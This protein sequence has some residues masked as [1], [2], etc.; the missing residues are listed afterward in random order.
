MQA[1]LPTTSAWGSEAVSEVLK[2]LGHRVWV[3]NAPGLEGSDAVHQSGDVD[4]AVEGLDHSWALR[5]GD[6][7]RVCQ[8]LQYNAV[9]CY[10][11]LERNGQVLAI[12][13]LADPDGIGPDAFPTTIVTHTDAEPSRAHRAAYLTAK[14]L[15]KRIR[16]PAE[17]ERGVVKIKN[18]A[19]REEREAAAGEAV[20]VVRSILSERA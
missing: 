3:L 6:G 15:R 13:T 19:T 9:G 14:R 1:A 11:V 2:L 8:Q 17:W 4:C 5:L 12:D 10:S 18:L 20:A 16:A 7:W